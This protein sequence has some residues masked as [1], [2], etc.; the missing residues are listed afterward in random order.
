LFKLRDR[1]AA[2]KHF[3]KVAA[4]SRPA[5]SAYIAMS[6]GLTDRLDVTC[7]QMGFAPT[8]YWARIVSEFGLLRVNGRTVYNPAYRLK[9][10]DVIY[11]N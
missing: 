7:L 5:I 4:R 11:P 6:K 1:G 10:A 3:K 2:R 9:P 8:I